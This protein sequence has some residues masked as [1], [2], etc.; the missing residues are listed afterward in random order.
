M[1]GAIHG[2]V[3]AAFDVA[4]RDA[5]GEE[6][7]FKGEA[8]AGEKGHEVVA[9]VRRRVL[10]LGH[11]PAPLKDPIARQVGA[12]VSRGCGAPG[13]RV[14]GVGHVQ[15][16]QG[17]GVA[18]GEEQEVV[19]AHA[20]HGDQVGL[21]EAAGQA[22]RGARPPARACSLADGGGIGVRQ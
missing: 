7:P 11:A 4:Q 17:L 5:G 18:H 9:P 8:T 21:R 20:R 16:G 13:D 22:G 6:G 1:R 12:Q 15:E 10:N 2:H 14:A 3:G 19:G